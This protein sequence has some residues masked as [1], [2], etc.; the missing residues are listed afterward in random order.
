MTNYLTLNKLL[1][2][3]RQFLWQEYVLCDCLLGYQNYAENSITSPYHAYLRAGGGIDE[4]DMI[5]D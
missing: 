2:L 3:K 4:W 1:T 5:D